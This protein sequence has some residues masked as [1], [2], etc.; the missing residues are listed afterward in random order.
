MFLF[1][2]SVLAERIFIHVMKILNMYSHLLEEVPLSKATA[3]ATAATNLLPISLASPIKKHEKKLEKEDK[4]EERKQKNI[5][6]YKQSPQYV[7][8][9]QLLKSAH[10]NYKVHW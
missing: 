3:S 1:Q 5:S 4:T 6:N 10:N 7:K 9:H 8:L 2:L